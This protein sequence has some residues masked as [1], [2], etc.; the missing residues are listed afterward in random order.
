M[1]V[2]VLGLTLSFSHNATKGQLKEN[3]QVIV[4]LLADLSQTALFTVEFDE[5]Q[6]YM[7]KII[8]DPHILR[9]MVCNLDGVVVVSTEFSDVGKIMPTQL[10][11]TAEK[12]WKTKNIEGF[13]AISIQFSNSELLAATVQVTKLGIGIALSGMAVIA[14]A[15]LGFGFLLTRRL[16]VLISAAEQMANGDLSVKTG[17]KG[18]DEVSIVGQTFDYMTDKVKGNIAELELQKQELSAARDELEV[19]VQERTSELQELNA[20]LQQLSEMDA[21]TQIPNRRRFD[22]YLRQELSRAHRANTPLSLIILDIDSFKSF[23]DCYGHQGGDKCL[24]N[25]ARVIEQVSARRAADLTA[26]YGGEEFTVIL[27]DT[28]LKGAFVIAEKIRQEIESIQ[29]EHRKSEVSPYVTV[30][31][32]VA[33]YTTKGPFVTQEQLIA[34]AD[35]WLYEAKHSGRNR[36]AGPV[37]EKNLK[38]DE[39]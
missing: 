10:A 26:R 31:V 11:S 9:V 17:F 5:L 21:L 28:D 30:S 20:K 14:I 18:R 6:Q 27:P 32:G 37:V 1:M 16:S 29:M 24:I 12:F 34:E 35:R 36:V 2:L 39:T 4:A 19:R 3:E 8:Q 13:G 38:C 22:N 33:T 7:E 23:N 25:V 15:G